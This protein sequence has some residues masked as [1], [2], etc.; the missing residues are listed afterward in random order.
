MFT[1]VLLCPK[2]DCLEHEIAACIKCD[3]TITGVTNWVPSSIPGARCHVEEVCDVEIVDSRV[4][5]QDSRFTH[6][7]RAYAWIQIHEWRP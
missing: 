2:T 1:S 3:A 6:I 4:V 5:S 7:K